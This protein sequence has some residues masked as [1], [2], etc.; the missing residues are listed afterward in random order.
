MDCKNCLKVLQEENNYCEECG[1]KVIR[2][3]L[4]LKSVWVEFSEKVFNFDNAFFKTF[5][6]LFS[7]PEEVINGYINGVR[8]KYI[9]VFSY[10]ALAITFAGLQIFIIRKFFPESLD[11]NA[12]IPEGSPQQGTNIDWIYDYYSLLAL[13]NLPIYA[14]IAKLVFTGFKKYNY[15]EH[16]VI[17]TYIIAQ[18]TFTNFLII[19]I[20]TGLGVNFYVIGNI[21]NVLLIIYSSYCYQ[22]LY[23]LTL[24]QSLMRFLLF[25]GILIVLLFLIGIIQFIIIYLNGDLQQMIEAQ[26]AQQGVSYSTSSFMNWTSYRFL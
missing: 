1:A 10:Y 15:T 11:I 13:L 20:A 25:L 3:R 9:P 6:A 17:F 19:L 21:L 5:L 23:P 2:N 12:L 4:T 18:Y 8:K 24:K 14:F 7:K 16:L 22:R 26:K